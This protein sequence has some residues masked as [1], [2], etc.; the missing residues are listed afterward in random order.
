MGGIVAGTDDCRNYPNNKIIEC[1]NY[2]LILCHT[3][4]R[5]GGIVGHNNYALDGC[6]N[7]GIILG[8]LYK[9]SHGPGWLCGYSGAST[10]TWINAQNCV[11]G[12]KLGDYS[13]YKDN[14]E[15]APATTNDNAFCY[16]S[17]YYNPDINK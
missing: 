7:Q 9:N 14:P 13:V 10:A 3:S 16:L 11:R 15:A 4:C 17:Q 12:G 2:G 1:T 5:T 8:N 6:S